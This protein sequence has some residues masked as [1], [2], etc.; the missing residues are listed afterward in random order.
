MRDMGEH[1][2]NLT[3]GDDTQ[4]T[5]SEET[6]Q[7]IREAMTGR[8]ITWGAKISEAKLRASCK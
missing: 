2:Y 1:I 3:A 7:K 5:M 4:I 6:K 8:V